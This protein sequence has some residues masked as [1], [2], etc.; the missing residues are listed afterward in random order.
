MK[1]RLVLILLLLLNKTARGQDK[2]FIFS[3]ANFEKEVLEYKPQ[4]RNT[5]SKNSYANAIMILNAVKVDTQNDP[6]KFNGADYWNV[7]IAFSNLSESKGNIE[8]AFQKII[9]HDKDR[10]CLYLDRMKHNFNTTIPELYDQQIKYCLKRKSLDRA[11]KKKET[12]SFDT[13]LLERMVSIQEKDQKYRK[14]PGNYF[15]DDELKAK[16]HKLDKENRESIDS[17]YAIH[18]EYIGE[19]KVGKAYGSTMF[20]VIQHSNLEMMKQYLPVIHK[21]VKNKDIPVGN[22]RL[23]IDRICAIKYN[24]QIFGTQGG[25]QIASEAIREKWIKEYLDRKNN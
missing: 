8:L 18:K 6:V 2:N 21:A 1:R 15:D 22:L 7:A 24:Y 17:L 4:K 12:D 20:I 3:Y 10:L 23:L 5:I 16:Q 19:S 11:K 13:K 14:L 25:I 9:D